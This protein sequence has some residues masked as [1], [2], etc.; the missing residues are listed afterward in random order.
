MRRVGL[1]T[2]EAIDDLWL[3]EATSAAI[4]AM[5][6]MIRSGAIASA[7]P[8]SRLTQGELGWLFGA[9]LFAW[10]RTRAEQATAEGWDTEAALRLTA[11][12]P[13]PWDAGAVAHVLPQLGQ[14]PGFDWSKPIGAWPKD[15]MVRF[16][17]KA[18][19]LIGEAMIARDVGGGIATKQ[20]LDRMQRVASAAGGGPLMT[21]EE[22]NQRTPGHVG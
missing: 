11:L 12:D 22:L 15:Q 19:R 5:Q 21:P 1:P 18:M 16:L 17:L 13:Q 4:G 20:S 14:L 9:G 7:T 8:L 2:P 10:T 3:Q 6:N